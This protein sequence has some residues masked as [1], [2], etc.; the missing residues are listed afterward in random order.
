M[1]VPAV[2]LYHTTRQQ[3]NKKHAVTRPNFIAHPFSVNRPG[4]CKAVASGRE[5]NS[6]ECP[7]RLPVTDSLPLKGFRQGSRDSVG[8]R[9]AGAYDG[10]TCPY[11]Y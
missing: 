2:N 7:K 4:I 1:R 10:S 9:Y 8:I 11:M 5:L 6:Q 3:E